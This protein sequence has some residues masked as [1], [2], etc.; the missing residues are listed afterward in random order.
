MYINCLLIQH[1]Q[2]PLS[3][4]RSKRHE[5][6]VQFLHEASRQ[7]LSFGLETMTQVL[8][9]IPPLYICINWSWWIW[10]PLFTHILCRSW[11]ERDHTHLGW[12]SIWNL[13]CMWSAVT[14]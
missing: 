8:T 10:E 12:Q 9:A 6:I 4:A 1:G 11:Q 13:Q 7:R 2:T 5:R 14:V 3:F